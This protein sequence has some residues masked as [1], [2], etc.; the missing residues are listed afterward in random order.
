MPDMTPSDPALRELLAAYPMVVRQQIAWGDMDA[1]RHVNNVAYFRYFENAR[2]EYFARLDWFKFE[3][4]SG[5]GPIVSATQARFRRALTFPDVALVGTRLLTL[6]EDR[7]TLEHRLVSEKLKDIATEGQVTV[8]AYRYAEQQK[9]PL[10]DEL[11]RRIEALERTAA[12][13]SAK[14]APR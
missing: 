8:V 13:G 3:R 7:F 4:E 6:Q 10:P 9:T 14:P 11:K 1:C 2:L 5:V 12:C